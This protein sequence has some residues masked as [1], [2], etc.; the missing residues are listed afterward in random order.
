MATLEENALVPLLILSAPAKHQAEITERLLPAAVR[1][2]VGLAFAAVVAQQ[3]IITRE[4]A[5][6]TMV[7]EAAARFTDPEDLRDHAPTL[8]GIYAGL[9]EAVK[10]TIEF[11]DSSGQKREREQKYKEELEAALKEQAR[12]EQAVKGAAMNEQPAKEQITKEQTGR[13]A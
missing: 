5:E 1:G 7:K 11:A 4:Q 2:P 6:L 10:E 3:Q 8:F 13:K 9:P 12:K